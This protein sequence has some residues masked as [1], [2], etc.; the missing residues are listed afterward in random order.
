MKITTACLLIL[1]GLA[2]SNTRPAR[3][4]SDRIYGTVYTCEDTVYQGAIRWDDHETFWDDVL[5]ATKEIESYSQGEERR[6]R[7]EI[8]IF[9]MTISWTVT[10]DDHESER[11]FGIRIG[12]L[13]SIQRR[14]RTSAVLT[15][16]DDS[17]ILVT[18]SG[19]DIGSSN[20][21][22]VIEDRDLGQVTVDW[23][24][25]E[26]ILFSQEP[27]DVSAG[28]EEWRLFGTVTAWDGQQFRG[29]ILWDD[30]E[31]L[32]SDV[33]DGTSRD[34]D[35]EIPFSRIRVVER[36]SSSSAMVELTTGKK[37][38][39]RGT[40][41]VDEDNRGIVVQVPQIGRVTLEWDDFDRAEFEKPDP[42]LLRGYDDYGAGQPLYG[43]VWNDA[44][45]RYRGR[46]RWDDDEAMAY[47]FLDGKMGDLDVQI[48]FADIQSIEKR[49]SRS[50]VIRLKSGEVLTLKGTCDVNDNNRGIYIEDESKILVR[51][52]WNDLDRVEFGRP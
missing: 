47:E 17:R 5:N 20:R 39:L 38:R 33:L 7:N 3:A 30:D 43:T 26:K 46:I 48:E 45:D 51:L 29:F 21:G 1:L 28:R 35:L 8:E 40:N 27:D 4:E 13:R 15:L 32:S 18:G 42:A 23:S 16:K 24:D 9:G 11:R 49:S 25:F 52:S 14:S 12:R 41:D 22:I 6:K 10:E 50:A 44:G 31:C 19:T 34:E 2:A 36:K 37:I